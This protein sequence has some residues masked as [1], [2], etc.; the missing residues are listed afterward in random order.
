MNL[1]TISIAVMLASSAFFVGGCASNGHPHTAGE[2]VDDAA[3][4]TKVKAAL[5]AE[6]DVNSMAI[7]VKT[8]NGTVQLSGF[9]DSQWQIAKAGQVTAAIGGVQNVRNDLI[10]KPK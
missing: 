5:L 9:V 10:H 1:K 4:T 3:I 7:E 2:V 8:F 6:K